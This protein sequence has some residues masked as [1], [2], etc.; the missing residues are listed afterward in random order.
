MPVSVFGDIELD[1]RKTTVTADRI[2]ITA[3]TPFGDIDVLVP[4]GVELDVGG[5]T[6]FG[7]KKITAPAPVMPGSAPLVRIRTF[8]VFGNI[9]VRSI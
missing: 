3:T 2:D 9:N 7:N 1:L 4:P 6:L 8:S 5:F